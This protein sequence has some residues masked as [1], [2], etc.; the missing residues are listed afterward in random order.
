MT[1]TPRRTA[2]NNGGS[3][4]RTIRQ[5]LIAEVPGTIL[6]VNPSVGVPLGYILGKL[7]GR[8]VLGLLHEADR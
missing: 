6:S 1:N 7:T 3:N 2:S 4:S 8:S 5:H